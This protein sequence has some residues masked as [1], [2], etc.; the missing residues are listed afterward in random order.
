M[1]TMAITTMKPAMTM[2]LPLTLIVLSAPSTLML[3]T[4]AHD[5]E[6]GN[7]TAHEFGCHLINGL[8]LMKP[9]KLHGTVSMIKPSRSF[10]AT[11]SL[12]KVGQDL[13]L[14]DH[15]SVNL[16]HPVS[17]PLR[18]T[19]TCM[20]FRPMIFFLPIFMILLQLK[21]LKKLQ[22]PPLSWMPLTKHLTPVSLMQLRPMALVLSHLVISVASCPSLQHVTLTVPALSILFPSMRQLW[23][24]VC[25]SLTVALTVVLLVMTS[26]SF[27]APTVQLTLRVLIITMSTTLVLVLLE[28][29]FRHNMVQ[30]LLSCINM[31]YLAKVPPFIPL[32]SLSGIRT[33]S[34]ISL[35]MFLVVFNAL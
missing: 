4:S 18:L 33:M 9:V 2:I 12:T 19:P 22:M 8:V 23:L 16:L 25:P 31:P 34:M 6:W 17:L 1:M 29:L 26:A 11:P 27:F 21:L 10:W 7:L 15:P 5:L 14:R 20:R 24:I 28:V 13:R 35:F 3:P 32:V 30:S